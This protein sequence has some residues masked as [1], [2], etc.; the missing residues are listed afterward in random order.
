MKSLRRR[1]D[2]FLDA[3]LDAIGSRLV[4]ELLRARASGFDEGRKVW[5]LNLGVNGKALDMEGNEW[6]VKDPLQPVSH[7]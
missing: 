4:Y 7:D 6:D 5:T 2:V 3:A 1:I